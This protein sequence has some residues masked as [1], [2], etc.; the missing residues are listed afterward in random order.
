MAA[1]ANC[2]MD[3]GRSRRPAA[4]P[5]PLSAVLWPRA[6]AAAATAVAREEVSD[7]CGWRAASQYACSLT[8]YAYLRRQAGKELAV[9]GQSFPSRSEEP[10]EL[11][12]MTSKTSPWLAPSPRHSGAVQ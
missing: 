7:K 12:W 1:L 4:D 2:P 9:P 11:E 5:S 6:A 3:R 8:R 10:G